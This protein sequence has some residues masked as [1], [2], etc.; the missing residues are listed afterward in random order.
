MKTTS[1]WYRDTA[2]KTK[3]KTR[4]FKEESCPDEKHS[5]SAAT[6]S[7]LKGNFGTSLK[8]QVY[9]SCVLPAMT[10]GAETWTVIAQAKNKLAAALT[11]MERSMLYIT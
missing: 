7:S 5:S 8:R 11:K 1:T 4:R 9:N 3:T 10:H 6:S 2:P